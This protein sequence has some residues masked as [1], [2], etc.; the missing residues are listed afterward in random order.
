MPTCTALTRNCT[1]CTSAAR[2]PEG[3]CGTHARMVDTP[4]K[5]IRFNH[6]QDIYRDAWQKIEAGTHILVGT[7]LTPIATTPVAPPAP[8]A[9]PP[10]ICGHHMGNGRPCT[11][12]STINGKCSLHN[13]MLVRRAQDVPFKAARREMRRLNRMGRTPREID[14]Y[15]ETVLPG[16]VERTRRLILWEADELAVRGFFNEINFLF[17]AGIAFDQIQLQVGHWIVGGF[18]SDR[19]GVTVLAYA[20][21]VN[22]QRMW[23]ANNPVAGRAPVFGA[24][25]REAQLAHDTQNVHTQEVSKQM[26]DSIDI[27]LKVKVPNTQTNTVHEIRDCWRAQ[28][29]PEHEI[30]I[31]YAD[32]VSWWNR[33]MIYK[34]GDKTYKR[35]LRGLWYTIKSYTGETRS[36]LEKRL[37]DECKDAAIPYSVCA[38]GHM[39]R[40][41]NVMVG[42]DEAFVPPVPVGEILQQKMAAI[43]EMDIESEKQIELAKA[44]LV[45]L[46]IPEEKHGD[47]LA[48]F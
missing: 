7:R 4:E 36:E 24:N 13:T 11:R 6:D 22:A 47:W 43:A 34:P 28:G 25:Q 19:R 33:T 29:R 12:Q 44:L 14:A 26:Q 48:A 15:V 10:A 23:R 41:S 45:E 46:K 42:F 8:I 9:P 37:W 39:A 16:L 40:L 18:L 30:T 31:V 27:L 1:P 20:N 17:D 32:V 38:T 21:R 3:L 5:R 2:G 35:C